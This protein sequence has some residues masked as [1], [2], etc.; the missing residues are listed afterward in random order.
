[1]LPS[2]KYQEMNFIGSFF[3]LTV[4]VNGHIVAHTAAWVNVT[5]IFNCG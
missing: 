2:C 1:M 5:A 4:F 3:V